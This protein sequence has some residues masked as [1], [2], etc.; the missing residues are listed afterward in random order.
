MT[1]EEADTGAAGPGTKKGAV[2][3]DG[4]RC[5]DD[6]RRDSHPLL[7]TAALMEMKGLK[8]QDKAALDPWQSRGTT[9]ECADADAVPGELPQ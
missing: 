1:P 5:F 8:R 7:S 9:D 4:S 6:G 2:M 3:P